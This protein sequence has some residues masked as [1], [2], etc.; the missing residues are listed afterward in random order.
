MLLK[1]KAAS[2]QRDE[3]TALAFSAL[4]LRLAPMEHEARYIHALACK[5]KGSLSAAIY[6]AKTVLCSS[7][8]L[9]L[10][11]GYAVLRDHVT[12]SL[13]YRSGR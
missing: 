13:M 9:T 4:L 3:A 12:A 2:A 6:D 10:C 5:S 1:C 7:G 11:P 8:N